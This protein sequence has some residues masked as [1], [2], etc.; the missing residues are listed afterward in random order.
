[1][2]IY[3]FET[4]QI[5]GIVWETQTGKTDYMPVEYYHTDVVDILRL[6]LR[7]NPKL[8]QFLKDATFADVNEHLV[9]CDSD[10]IEFN[11]RYISYDDLI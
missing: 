8:V 6:V 7:K 11:G 5:C 10:G 1:M 4:E 2:Y 9:E 3:T